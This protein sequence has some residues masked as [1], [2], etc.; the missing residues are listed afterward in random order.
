MAEQ[1]EAKY[2]GQF[3]VDLAQD[4]GVT[5]RLELL[6]FFNTKEAPDNLKGGVLVHSKKNGQGF[7]YE[8]WPAFYARLDKAIDENNKK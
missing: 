8:N 1:L 3:R 5:G 2:P 4:T 6:L 7:G